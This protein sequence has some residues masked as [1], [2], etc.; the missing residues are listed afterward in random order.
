[1]PC[2]GYLFIHTYSFL[3]NSKILIINFTVSQ[4]KTQFNLQADTFKC[5]FIF[6]HNIHVHKIHMH[7]KLYHRYT[8]HMDGAVKQLI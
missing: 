5:Q 6:I 8:I 2:S 4:D 7:I 3:T 1:M